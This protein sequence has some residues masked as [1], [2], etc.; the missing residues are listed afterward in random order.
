[1]AMTV[2]HSMMLLRLIYLLEFV[3]T[4]SLT[5]TSGLLAYVENIYYICSCYK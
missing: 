1:M 3:I 2:C 5:L 4:A